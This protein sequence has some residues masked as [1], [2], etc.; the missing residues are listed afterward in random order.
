MAHGYASYSNPYSNKESLSGFIAGKIGSAAKMAASER[1]ARDEEIK[2]L[3][4]KEELSDEE[5]ERLDFL[6]NQQGGRKGSFFG[7]ALVS[8]FGGD[9]ARRLKGTFSKDPSAANDPA[10]SKEQRF[11]AV[12]DRAKPAEDPIQPETPFQPTIP[13]LEGAA[14]E[15]KTPSIL[16][17][18]FASIAKS[19]DSIADRVSSLASEEKK[20]VTN[21][22][23]NNKFLSNITSGLQAIKEYFNK[24]NDLKETENNIEVQQLE[25]AIDRREDAEMDAK[26]ASMEMGSDLSGVSAVEGEPGNEVKKGGGPLGFIKDLGGKLM[27]MMGNK[28]AAGKTQYSNPIG[29]QP[30]NSPTPWAA[31]GAGEMGNSQGFVPR[32]PS[33]PVQPM[34][35][36]GIIPKTKPTKLAA[37]GIVD[38]PTTTKLNPGDSVV[39]LNRNNAM[40]KMFKAAGEGSAGK[41]ITD[42][43]SKVMQ[44]PS[45]VGG[46]LMLSLLADVMNKLG[47]LGNLL[48]PVLSPIAGPL[49][50][51]F[52]LPP[53]IINAMFGGAAQA[54]TFDPAKYFDGESESETGGTTG[55]DGTPTTTPPGMGGADL[56]ASMRAGETIQ[57]QG[58]NDPGG[59]IQGGSGLG[60]EGGQ[61]TSGGYATHYHLSPPS[62]DAAG[63]AQAR[64]V[65]KTSAQMMLNRGSKIYFGNSKQWANPANLDAQ[66]AAEQQAHTQ[67]GRT[68]GGIDMQEQGPGGNMRLKFPLKV[69]NVTNDINGGS[70]RTARIIGTNVRLAHGAAGSAN[71]VE[72]AAMPQVA[73]QP[74]VTLPGTDPRQP[75]AANPLLTPQAGPQ[76][77]SQNP[78]VTLML[79]QAA[80]QRQQ[81]QKLDLSSRSMYSVTN[82]TGI[83]NLY[84]WSY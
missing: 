37:G 52:G 75:T 60:S 49:A 65:A 25:L 67:P 10:L 40:G 55:P 4:E 6:T 56:G 29:P 72:S 33:A 82:P 48:K 1:K 47:G 71:S 32:M 34:S 15:E 57:A 51:V 79:Q 38:N 68:Q 50:G 27:N 36:G 9:R 31:R 8:E 5:Q 42:P 24:D 53:T 81:Q 74:P 77:T 22:S 63:W 59:F 84:Q 14:G 2:S 17:K 43:M 18:A 30:M 12:L 11:S 44:L 20:S 61:N 62:N 80:A 39:P 26:Q 45:Q 13:G 16:Q 54:A 73:N 58:A 70:G 66:I 69:T 41:D 21:D 3:Q 35:K 46:G 7:K 28:G 23:D 78:F 83:G 76:G 64:A 19:Y